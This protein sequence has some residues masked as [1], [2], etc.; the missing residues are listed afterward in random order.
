MPNFMFGKNVVTVAVEVTRPADTTAY[1]AND[2]VSDSTSAT[3]PL[4]FDGLIRDDGMSA[5]VVAARVVTNK[6]GITPRIR[7]HLLNALPVAANIAGDNLPYKALYADTG[8]RVAVFDLGAMSTPADNTN[9]DI[10]GAA[11]FGLRI[12]L[13]AAAGSKRLYAVLETLD[14]FTPD[15]GQKFTLA[16]TVDRY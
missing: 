13:Q 10:S 9:S 4:P 16:L 8:K 11:D 5:Y 3:T 7:V 6:K 2:V 15:A 1:A 12:P 14:A